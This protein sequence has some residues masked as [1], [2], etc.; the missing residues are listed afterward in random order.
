[1]KQA[2]RERLR[3]CPER[4]V[5]GPN[6]KRQRLVD[7]EDGPTEPGPTTVESLT[8]MGD[9]TTPK[10]LTESEPTTF[11]CAK[12]M[13]LGTE[14][15]T[16]PDER[17]SASS[18][19]P[20]TCCPAKAARLNGNLRWAP[21][22]DPDSWI[23]VDLG[24]STVVSGVITQGDTYSNLFY[25]TNYKVAYQKQPSSDLLHVTDGNGNI[26]MFTANTDNTTP[27]TN[28]FDENVLATVVRI[29]PI[30]WSGGVRLR[31]ELLGCRRD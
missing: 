5:L 12:P 10:T 29:E 26:K 4:M 16:I 21:A 25:V 18:S 1:M 11:E 15:G 23:E 9:S 8:P 7:V 19:Y 22:T 30:A 6:E 28:L 20:S 2:M 3:R 13:P 14:D 27:V 24:E 17:F 31:L